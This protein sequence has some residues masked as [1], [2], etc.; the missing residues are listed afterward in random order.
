MIISKNRTS[1][2]W[3]IL[4]FLALSTTSLFAAEKVNREIEVAVNPEF[5]FFNLRGSI[6]IKGWDKQI[7]KVEGVLDE[8]STGLFVE[9]ND[10]NII[11]KVK[12][13]RQISPEK[14]SKLVIFV[15][16]TS[17]V[18]A[19]G[20]SS[21]WNIQAVDDILINS[22][23]GE[24][25]VA[26]SSGDV[27]LEVVSAPVTVKAV[28]GDLNVTSL[29]G[30]IKVQDIAGSV[31]LNTVEGELNFKQPNIGS[32]R[33]NSVNGTINIEGKLSKTGNLSVTSV[34]GDVF[35]KVGTSDDLNCNFKALHGGDIKNHLKTVGEESQQFSGKSFSLVIGEGK[36]LVEATT[37]SGTIH[38][39]D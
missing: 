1:S 30:K 15:P 3:L 6:E 37:I 38:L 21:S 19:Q 39:Q 7:L 10:K 27:D 14:G 32:A 33:L 24:I 13:P 18:E 34:D 11:V 12:M 26:N 20:V 36:A 16:R 8:E 25:L 31:S 23:S 2:Q 22:V 28:S 29:S 5:K 35:L 17:K 4:V 9:E